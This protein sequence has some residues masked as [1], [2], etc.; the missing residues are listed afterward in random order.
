MLFMYLAGLDDRFVLISLKCLT[1]SWFCSWQ[2]MQ[3]SSGIH[4]LCH[5]STTKYLSLKW[6]MQS[7]SIIT[8]L[9]SCLYGCCQ[10][11]SINGFGCCD[12]QR[13][14]KVTVSISNQIHH[15]DLDGWS[16]ISTESWENLSDTLSNRLQIAILE[17]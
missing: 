3:V 10:R 8:D 7:I 1:Q 13:I 11:K 16:I 9:I 6:K 4:Q 14:V 12:L 17:F 5:D 2:A 15:I